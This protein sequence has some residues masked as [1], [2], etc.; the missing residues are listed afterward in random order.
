MKKTL[1]IA[2]VGALALGIAGAEDN[3][4]T[5]TTTTTTTGTTNSRAYNDG[6][7]FAT[8]GVN[9]CGTTKE[10]GKRMYS[11]PRDQYQFQKNQEQDKK[12]DDCLNGYYDGLKKI[13]ENNSNN[14]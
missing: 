11:I 13:Q 2:L 3:S 12:Y 4:T 14:N 9:Q 5:T 1:F 6:R 10:T 7:N 8:Q